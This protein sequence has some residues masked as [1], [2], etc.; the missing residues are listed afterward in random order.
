MNERVKHKRELERGGARAS[1][2]DAMRGGT[3]SGD[4]KQT[5]NIM[6]LTLRHAKYT[7]VT[8]GR[9]VTRPTH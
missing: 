5:H 4:E 2:C 3:K 6:T 9:G 8:I 1:G 7:V